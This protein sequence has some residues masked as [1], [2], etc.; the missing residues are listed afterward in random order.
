[1]WRTVSRLLASAA[2]S[3]ALGGCGLLQGIG[4]RSAD[5][6]R[7]IFYKNVTTLHLDFDARAALNTDAAD[8]SGLSLPTLVRV[9]QLRDSALLR[10]LSYDQLLDSASRL[11][12]AD[13]LSERSLVLKPGSSAQ[14]Q[15]PLEPE[16]RFVAVLALF[17]SVDPHDH[18]WRVILS[19]DA[20]DPDRPR[21]LQLADRHLTLRPLDED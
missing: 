21:V 20:L 17:R 5:L 1:M 14:L 7:A 12:G 6:G 3:L 18:S 8:M 11:L 16:A 10:R 15:L 4:E 9:Y 13:L 19:R 2:L